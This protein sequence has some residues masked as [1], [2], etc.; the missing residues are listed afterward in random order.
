MRHRPKVA[1]TLLP[2]LVL[3]CSDNFG[4]PCAVPRVVEENCQSPEPGSNTNCVMTDN[5]SCDSRI[6]AVWQD[7]APF[8][9]VDCQDD[10]DCPDEASC[11][12]FFLDQEADKFCV[13]DDRLEDHPAPEMGT[14]TGGGGAA[15]VAQEGE[16]EAPAP[17]TEG[18]GEA[19]VPAT[20]GEG[21]G[22]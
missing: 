18:E 2:L 11:V 14:S 8:C 6:C 15:P 12:P 17:A 20:E 9:T 3:G 4:E 5:L 22:E 21:E 13:L 16:G 10:A 7:S 1:A 19:P